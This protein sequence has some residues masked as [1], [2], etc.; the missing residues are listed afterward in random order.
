MSIQTMQL[1]ENCD[2]TESKLHCS[3]CNT[4]LCVDCDIV[5]HKN[6]LKKLHVRSIT[7]PDFV[8][9][10]QLTAPSV[11]EDLADSSKDGVD[12]SIEQSFKTA[13][14]CMHTKVELCTHL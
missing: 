12:A 5:L 4:K 6:K 10:N 7:Q 2:E 1:C 11:I 9:L 14:V 13:S 8:P 3:T